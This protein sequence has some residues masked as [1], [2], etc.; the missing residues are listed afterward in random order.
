MP[1]CVDFRQHVRLARHDARSNLHVA[2]REET[3]EPFLVADFYRITVAHEPHVDVAFEIG[4]YLGP[5]LGRSLRVVDPE[6]G[7]LA[8]R[9]VVALRKADVAAH[10]PDFV[11]VHLPSIGRLGRDDD[12]IDIVAVGQGDVGK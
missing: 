5:P 1:R 2:D 4:D 6:Y 9:H 8:V 3:G 11:V 12:R 7:L 10:D